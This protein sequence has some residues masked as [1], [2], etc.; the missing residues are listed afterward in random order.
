MRLYRIYHSMSL[1]VGEIVALDGNIYQHLLQVLRLKI[2][3]KFILFNGDTKEFEASILK[4]D[5]KKKFFLVIIERFI[6]INR[7][8]F[9]NIH[10]A[11]GISCSDK[12]DFIIQKAVELG[13]KTI[14]PLFTKYCNVKLDANQLN[15]K[16]Y[17]WRQIAIHA[18]EQSGRN[19][20]PKII[21]SCHIL[22]WCKIQDLDCTKLIFTPQIL[23]Q[24]NIKY[25]ISN[26]V[27]IVIGPEGGFSDK[28][29]NT[30]MIHKF[31]PVS[32]GNRILRTE[33]ASIAIISIIQSKWG[34]FNF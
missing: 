2:K 19:Y 27:I 8:S 29:I 28:E 10:L 7:E 14:T 16:M 32:L 17:R 20:I 5:K 6:Q 26:N 4:I 1:S 30:A 23:S 11:Q 24:N 33:T 13:V 18:A 9:L 3:D 21:N 25:N 31:I 22:D 12:M 15:K 34:D